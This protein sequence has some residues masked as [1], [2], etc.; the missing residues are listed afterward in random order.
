[1]ACLLLQND[2]DLFSA[3]KEN[4]NKNDPIFRPS[5]T[6][7]HSLLIKSHKLSKNQ[8][9]F[10]STILSNNIHKTYHQPI[11]ICLLLSLSL[12][13]LVGLLLL[14]DY[15]HADVAQCTAETN[16]VNAEPALVNAT[17]AYAAAFASQVSLL[18]YEF[19]VHVFVLTVLLLI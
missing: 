16:K 1:M 6:H 9:L 19:V 12:S 18:L 13:F 4:K 8:S 2:F 14:V 15:N 10:H 11:N 5:H 17:A 3:I 7:H